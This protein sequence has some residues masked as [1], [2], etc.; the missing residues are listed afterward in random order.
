MQ[1]SVLTTSNIERR[2]IIGVPLDV[3]DGNFKRKLKDYASKARIDGFRPGKVPTSVVMP[4]YGKTIHREIISE[5]IETY[6]MKALEQSELRPVSSPSIEKVVDEPGADFKFE[7]VVE[8]WP[9]VSLPN[10]EK[11]TATRPVSEVSD[12]DLTEMVKRLRTERASFDTVETAADQ[13][14][15]A[16]I[17]FEGRIDGEVFEGGKGD[18]LQ[19]VIGSGGM[20]PGF[21]GELVGLK[22]GDE[23]IFSVVF[24]EDY[25][26]AQLANK[27]AEFTVQVKQVEQQQLPE[28]DETFFK[29][30]DS[31]A[32]DL[33][34]FKIEL[35]ENMTRELELA[36]DERSRD[37][38]LSSIIEA[39]P[40]KVPRGLVEQQADI[41]RD[42]ALRNVGL[43][44]EQY[45]AQFSRELFSDR[46]AFIVKKVV[47]LREMIKKYELEAS[48]EAI[49][50][51]L[52]KVAARFDD[53]EAFKSEQRKSP[54]RM[55][56]VRESVL[57]QMLIDHA[58]ELMTI[59][60]EKVGYFDLLAQRNKN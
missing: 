40:F 24:P 29:Q 39:K 27:T 2:L 3:V 5:L 38:V 28:L 21:E 58:A 23:K 43:D 11:L 41:M 31:E 52:D 53:P 9:E 36:I 45:R 34:S 46:A 32:Q 8:V 49:E 33:E 42:Q 12:D 57:E 48:D 30:F 44:P 19:I 25:D 10:L 15:R 35:K 16:T 50:A 54:E 51:Y 20:I 6:Y 17:D 55:E 13:N 47:V 7:A 60:E 22:A 56:R 1:V 59:K 37:N 4:R 14:D 18:D 26:R